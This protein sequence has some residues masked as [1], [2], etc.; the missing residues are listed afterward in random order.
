MVRQPVQILRLLYFFAAALKFFY[1]L[2][3]QLLVI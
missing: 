3:M 1:D 2:K